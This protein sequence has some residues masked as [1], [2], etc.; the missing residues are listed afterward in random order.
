AVPSSLN[1]PIAVQYSSGVMSRSSIAL[2]RS[3]STRWTICLVRASPP[4]WPS[5]ATLRRKSWTSAVS[6]IFTLMVL[7]LLESAVVVADGRRMAAQRGHRDAHVGE[8]R[9]AG[10]EL[11]QLLV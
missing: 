5:P 4:S 6:K 3:D 11:V 10:Q 9:Q 7:Y 8:Q 2:N 1:Q